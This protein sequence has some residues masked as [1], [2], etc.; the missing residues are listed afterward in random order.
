ML[1]ALGDRLGR[2]LPETPDVHGSDHE[3]DH[4]REHRDD[5]AGLDVPEHRD[6]DADCNSDDHDDHREQV[7]THDFSLSL[8]TATC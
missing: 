8:K 4:H 3:P 7:P 1:P 6:D 5:D 2:V